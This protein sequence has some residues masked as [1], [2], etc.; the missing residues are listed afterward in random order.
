MPRVVVH[1][2]DP[3]FRTVSFIQLLQKAGKR[4]S[5]LPEAKALVDDL[6][7]GKSFEVEFDLSEQAA[8][9]AQAANDLGAIVKGYGSE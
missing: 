5:S 1:G 4:K 9:F 3:G 8:A 7:A 6:L 2:W